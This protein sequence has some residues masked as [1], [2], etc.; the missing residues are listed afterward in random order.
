M[1]VQDVGLSGADDLTVLKWAARHNRILL[2]HDVAT[3]TY[4]AYERIQAGK[5]MPGVFEIR[6]SIPIGIQ[7]L[8]QRG[9]AMQQNSPNPE[10]SLFDEGWS[11]DFYQ[12]VRLLEMLC[13]DKPSVG[14]GSEADKEAVRFTSNVSFEFPASA[15]SEIVRSESDKSPHQLSVNFM[16]LA[17]VTGPLPAPYSDLILSRLKEK[18]GAL[19]D[20][21][22]MFNHRLISLMYRVR[23]TLRIGFDSK[24]PDQ[25]AYARYLFSLIGLGTDG[26]SDRMRLRDRS[27]LFYTAVLSQKPRSMSGLES[28]LSHYFGVI[29]KGKQLCGGWCFLAQ[30]QHTQIGVRGQN[31]CLGQSAVVGTRIWDQQSRFELHIGPLSY[32]EFIGFLPTGSAYIS[33]CTLVRFYA[34]EESDFDLVL[35]LKKDTVEI[36]RL[37]ATQGARLSRTSW[38]PIRKP[39]FE[40]APVRIKGR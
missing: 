1:R 15:V 13:P 4:Y 2:T 3:I 38:L 37:S 5:K 19:K 21:L 28:I 9:S 35:S 29:V 24:P 32:Q 20:F 34:G 33:L 12:A 18:D 27:L 7:Y 6:C 25:T 16:G 40:Y 8:W 11:F 36:G 31:N 26:L 17:G 14:E 23:K 39:V 10:Q 22:D 30:D